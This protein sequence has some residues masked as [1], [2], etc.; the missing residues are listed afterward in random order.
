MYKII[1]TW[2]PDKTVFS[3]L[4]LPQIVCS[5]IMDIS[6]SQNYILAFGWCLIGLIVSLYVFRHTPVE[7][8][9]CVYVVARLGESMSGGW[10]L[11]VQC[12]QGPMLYWLWIVAPRLIRTCDLLTFWTGVWEFVRCCIDALVTASVIETIHLLTIFLPSYQVYICS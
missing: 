9:M 2:I 1:N 8:F 3:L 10:E 4:L 11:L 6:R 5:H 7:F 12:R